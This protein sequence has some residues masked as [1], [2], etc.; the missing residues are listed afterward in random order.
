MSID[1]TSFG[2]NGVARPRAADATDSRWW[3]LKGDE[4]CGSISATLVSMAE[5]QSRRQMQ[6]AVSARLYGNLGLVGMN[7]LSF[8]RI[9]GVNPAFKDRIS[10]NVVSSVIDT[11]TS[12]IGK[13]KPKPLFLTSGGD[14]RLQRKAKKLNKFVD[15]VFYENKAY[16]LGTDV[17]RD[18]AVWGT[19]VVHV[20]KGNGRV[21]FE[22][23]LDSEIF[24]DEF[25]A[26]YGEPRQLHRCKAVDRAVLLDAFP[27]AKAIIKAANAMSSEDVGG[28]AI[29]NVSDMVTVRE[30]WHL[31]SGPDAKDGRHLITVENGILLDEEWTKP[32]FPFAFFPWCK[33]LY[34][35]WGQGA[36]ERLQ[37][38]QLEINKLLWV[39]QRS[40]HLA[41]SF[42][43]LIENTSKIVKEHINNDIGALITYSG[44]P[45]QYVVPPAVPPEVYAHLLRLIQLSFEQEGVSML[46][47]AS[48]K[49]AG[50]DSGKAL[51]EY[52]EIESDRF[53]TI[54]HAYEDLFLDMARLAIATVKD[55]A[56]EE[57]GYTV[58]VPGKKFIETI[59]W[60]DVDLEED[61]YVMQCYPVS[62]LPN[63]PSGRLQTIQEYMQAGLLSP[64]QGKKL[65]DFPDLEQVESLQNAEE[66]WL[67][68]VLEK[69]VDDG[70]FT[71]PEP[72]DDLG[73]AR[74]LALEFYAQGKSQNLEPERLEMLRRFVDQIDVLEQA[75]LPPAPPA[76]PMEPQAMAAPAPVSDLV[77]NVPPVQ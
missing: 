35:F 6:H 11:I 71:P 29:Q 24:V 34:G 25:E 58:K 65:L 41:G 45:P 9:N 62:S 59:D 44:N 69:I 54:G 53:Q 77:P 32:F 36:A 43:V 21:K 23:V 40:M 63:D 64:R 42:K 1:H 10:Y 38:L 37:N 12:K 31:P 18:G 14:Y 55:I 66:E 19:G 52:N 74:E 16:R 50:L 51:R 72:F 46:S 61:E 70:E 13:N 17:F 49:P 56:E 57:G 8:T 60:A 68:Q 47:A 2:T 76:P 67:T 48:R 39:I 73:L 7:G 33:R 22:R 3:L 5:S 26:F 30:S 4:A 75:A 15:G 20:F 27:G 28:G